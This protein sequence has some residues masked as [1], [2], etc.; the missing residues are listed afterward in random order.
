MP[1]MAVHDHDDGARRDNVV[2]LPA[3]DPAP[4]DPWADLLGLDEE[5][6]EEFLRQWDEVDRDAAELVREALPEVMVALA[7]REDL[8]A[9]A[10]DVRSGV[11][12]GRW[13]HR[14]IAAAAGW[15][16]SPPVDDVE[17]WLSAAGAFVAMR[18]E[19]GM[20]VEADSL[21]TS[22]EH[23]DWLGAVIGLVRA[24][25]GSRAEPTDLVAHIDATPEVDGVVDPEEAP[26]TESGF[27]LVLPAW[28]AVGALDDRRRL[29]PLGWWGLPR[30]LV[31]A[32]DGTDL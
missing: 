19:S 18:D 7:P 12:V 23:A 29:T 31:W 26:L 8:R 9:A 1:V 15:S 11:T 5:S 28:E 25:V 14:H 3:P 30:T 6:E 21:L 4:V 17:L 2:P 10:A 24:G 27:E 13:P 20:D 32:W 22:M 16:G